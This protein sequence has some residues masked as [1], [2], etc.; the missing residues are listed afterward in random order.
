MT[1][2]TLVLLTIALTGAF[3]LVMA[4]RA[5]AAEYAGPRRPALVRWLDRSGVVII[6]LIIAAVVARVV[7]TVF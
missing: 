4:V 2:S 1:D 7:N 6:T 5:V 3:A